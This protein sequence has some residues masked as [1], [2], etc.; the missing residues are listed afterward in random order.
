MDVGG[1]CLSVSTLPTAS[2]RSSSDQ[3]QW[4]CR[5]PTLHPAHLRYPVHFEAQEECIKVRQRGVLAL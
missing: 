2:M 3:G 5:V 4:I 1:W